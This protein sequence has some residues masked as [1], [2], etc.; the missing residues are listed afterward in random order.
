[1][2]VHPDLIDTL[3]ALPVPATDRHDSPEG[4]RENFKALLAQQMGLDPRV[5][6]ERLE[7]A[8]PDGNVIPV[9]VVR[10]AATPHD[11]SPGPAILYLHGGG[12]VYGELDGPSPM[13]RDLCAR[14]GLTVV[15]P[16]Y[17]LAPEHRFPAGVEDCFAVLEWLVAD[18]DGLGV[19]P[20]RIGVAGASAGGALAAA[21]ALMARD[22][23][24]P[25]LAHQCLLVPLLDDRGT[26]PSRLGMTDARVINGPG[27]VG[28]WNS[29]LGADRDE[30]TTSPYAAPARADDLTG[31]PPAF[32]MTCGLD[33]LR[34]EGL[35]H[36]RRLAG[37][38][39]AVDAHHVP[40]A[41]HFFEGY[42]PHTDLARRTTARWIDAISDALA[43]AE[44]PVLR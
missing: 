19:D 5:R 44:V 24:G 32:V 9:D 21:V 26:T 22:R 7:V 39:V 14:A 28:T 31:L 17:R 23:G 38:D 25:A 41:W 37:A 1:M 30:A 43:P 10:P 16:D 20:A 15:S 11:A 29:Y 42:A 3:A 36:A 13:I 8:G 6:A 27:I 4:Q 35:E 33:P 18:A 12:F 34:D 40:G 2:N